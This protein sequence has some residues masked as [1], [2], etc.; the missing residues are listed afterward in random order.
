MVL[1]KKVAIST[2][3][4]DE[5]RPLKMGRKSPENIWLFG[6]MSRLIRIHTAF[7]ADCGSI[8]IME[9]LYGCEIIGPSHDD[10][11]Q[12][13]CKTKIEMSVYFD[14]LYDWRESCLL[15]GPICLHKSLCLPGNWSKPVQKLILHEHQLELVFQKLIFL[16]LLQ[17]YPL[18]L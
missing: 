9:Y 7:Y 4:G 3:N 11:R 8:V 10:A 13:D 15:I 17:Y 14:L 6:P 5:I 16:T 18:A 1:G 2:G 12:Y